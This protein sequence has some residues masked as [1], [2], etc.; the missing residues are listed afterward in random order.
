MEAT[1]TPKPW[2]YESAGQRKGGL[3]AELIA[4]AETSHGA[5]VWLG[6]FGL[7]LTAFI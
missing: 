2:F 3:M 1:E 4:A 6:C 7:M 5:I